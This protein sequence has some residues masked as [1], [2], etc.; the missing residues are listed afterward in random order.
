M[1]IHL[2]KL[3]A[4]LMLVLRPCRHARWRRLAAE[5][6]QDDRAVPGR[7]RHRLHRRAWP[8]STCRTGSA[9]R[10]S[11]RTAAAPTARIGLQAL[12]QSDP[13]GYTIATSSDTPLV[14]NPWLYDKLPYSGAAR[15]RRRSRR[16]VQVSRHAGGASLAF[17]RTP[18]PS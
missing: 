15:L 17:R 14:V 1:R 8:R 3:A 16:M 6:D 18:S 7:R 11:S 5:T 12:M 4:M 13:D 2:G 9:S 10:S